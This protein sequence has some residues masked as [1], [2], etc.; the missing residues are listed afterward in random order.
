MQRRS[1]NIK[2]AKRN[3]EQKL[4]KNVND[5]NKSFFSYV[6]SKQRIVEKVEPIKDSLGSL[7]TKDKDISCLLNNYF[8]SV[9]TL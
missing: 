7:I 9:F 5:D 3:F 1:Q 6:R 8:S 2:S 4:A